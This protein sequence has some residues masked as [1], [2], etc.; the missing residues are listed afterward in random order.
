LALQ[1]SRSPRA[2]VKY[3]GG[4]Q[5]RVDFLH[6]K[7]D[8]VGYV[9]KYVTKSLVNTVEGKADLSTALLFASNKRLFSMNDLRN[10]S[11]LDFHPR[12]SETSYESKGSA[13]LSLVESFCREIEINAQDFIMIESDDVVL[14]LWH[15][16]FGCCCEGG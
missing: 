1:S 2:R 6:G 15:D 4:Q 9:L 10:R 7:Y 13:P 11:M 14:S 8:V 5:L 3:G 16:I 12:V